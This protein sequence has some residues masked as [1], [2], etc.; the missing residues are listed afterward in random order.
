MKQNERAFTFATIS[1]HFGMFMKVGNQTQRWSEIE[2]VCA[3]IVCFLIFVQFLIRYLAIIHLYDTET[4]LGSWLASFLV[5]ITSLVLIESTLHLPFWF[6]VFG[7]LL[8]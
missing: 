4:S 6:L 1:L 2:F 5:L 7:L 8:L 3:Y